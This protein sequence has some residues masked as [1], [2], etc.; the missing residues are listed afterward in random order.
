MVP[1][2]ETQKRIVV[3]CRAPYRVILYRRFMLRVAEAIAE[4]EGALALVTGD[5]L[6][7]VASQ[8]LENIRTIEAVAGI[9]VLRPLVGLDKQEIVEEAKEIG[10]FDISIEPHDD[11]CSFLMPPNPATHSTPAEIEAA[12]GALDVSAEV[13][14]LIAAA[15]ARDVGRR[16]AA[17]PAAAEDSESHGPADADRGDDGEETTISPRMHAEPE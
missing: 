3:S 5:N 11:C 8:T 13:T 10:T 6:G 4:K 2:A 17:S 9:P 1:F 7:Q 14:R 15:E 16:W 12:E